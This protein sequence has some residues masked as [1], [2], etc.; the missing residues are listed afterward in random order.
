VRLSYFICEIKREE[1]SALIAVVFL[2][3]LIAMMSVTMLTITV[4]DTRMGMLHAEQR[5]A[6]Y[7]AQSGLEYGIKRVL[8]SDPTHLYDW[9]E[10]IDT[11]NETTCKVRVE[12]LSHNRFRVTA[13]G[14]SSKFVKKLSQ[15]LTYID[16][17]KYAIYTTG[18]VSRVVA[19]PWPPSSIFFIPHY[20][21]LV[22]TNAPVMPKFDL[23]ELRNLSLP[24]G[25]HSGNY[26]VGS[27]FHFPPNKF[28]F[29]EKNLTFQHWN[30]FGWGHFVARGRVKFKSA[31]LPFSAT[32]G[33]IYQPTPGKRLTS[34][35]SLLRRSLIGGVITNGNIQ[36]APWLFGSSNLYIFHHR[37]TMI[38]FLRHSV[39]ESPLVFTDSRWE[40][41][42]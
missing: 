41:M 8:L 40:N 28:V 1:G 14:R 2:M 17:S 21:S 15:T 36:G 31:W 25:Y 9:M 16:V 18:N 24:N 35:I 13:K 30:W 20:P 33:T 42:N 4:S 11:G 27:V 29:V 26:V 39:N 34:Q 12:F 19:H 10:E 6:F 23:D 3:M 7:A 38:K 37:N 5:R 32:F 22:Y